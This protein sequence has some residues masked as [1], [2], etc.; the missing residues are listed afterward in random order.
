MIKYIFVLFFTFSIF[1]DEKYKEVFSDGMSKMQMIEKIDKYLA[2]DLPGQLNEMKKE[3]AQFEAKNE[4]NISK[5]YDKLG[6]MEKR[7]E[8]M[9]NRLKEDASGK[10]K[11]IIDASSL[12]YLNDLKNI[13]IPAM[14][15]KLIDNEIELSDFIKQMTAK[16]KTDQTIKQELEEN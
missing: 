1:A 13:I 9:E 5:I 8:K 6:K 10:A 2:N 12:Q 4:A 15:K 7:I 11:S 14:Q 16:L 3:L